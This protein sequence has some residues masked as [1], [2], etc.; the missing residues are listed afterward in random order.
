MNFLAHAY[1]S[2]NHP[3]VLAGNMASDFIKGKAQYTY[4]PQMQAGIKLHRSI[5]AFTDNHPATKRAQEVFRKDYRLYSGPLVDIIYDHFLA[6]DKAIFEP[7][8]LKEFSLQ[9]YALLEAQSFYLPQ[10]FL[11]ILPY[12]KEQ[13][14]LFNY[15]TMQGIEQSLKGLVRRAAHLTDYATA[16]N[17]FTA[18]YSYLQTCYDSFFKDVKYNARKEF[19]QLVL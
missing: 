14:W 17:L 5:D 10:R 12:M 19:E 13:N 11:T 7:G 16:F 1:L 8:A 15:S 4:P 18:N 2:F 3:Q 6:I 9:V